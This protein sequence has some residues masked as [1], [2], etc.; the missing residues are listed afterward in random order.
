MV[1][2]RRQLRELY[3]FDFPEDFFRFWEFVN[4][5][6]PLEPLKALED[7]EI[8]LV[9]P[10]EILAGRFDQHTPRY[11]LLLHW[12]Y[13]FDPPEFFTVLS[14]NAGRD[15]MH[16][17]YYLDDPPGR[18]RC[19]VLAETHEQYEIAADGEDLFEAI[20]LWLEENHECC[21]LN[22]EEG[23][24][25]ARQCE[26]KLAELAAFRDCLLAFATAERREVGAD[27]ADRYAGM[28]LRQ[29]DVLADTYDGIGI[30]VPPESYWPLSRGDE[31][32]WHYLDVTDDPYDVV[33]E[34]RV[35]LCKGFPG[36]A[37]K[38]GKD[39]WTVG[40]ERHTEYAYELLDVAYA[41]LGREV[42]REVL[43]VHRENRDLP[44]V[45]ILENE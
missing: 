20:R 34:A 5:L 32:L 12:R 44:S 26:R 22:Q 13:Y 42:L 37:L 3:G 43:R 10:F 38:L 24:I 33:E 1:D 40:G 14:T 27:Y 18:S 23:M 31:S 39:L 4:R 29:E 30:V 35:A 21:E 2:R 9:G 45:D 6:H 16:W 11:S 7:L 36:T 19:V 17:G 41:A 25:S 15:A 8:Q 28:V